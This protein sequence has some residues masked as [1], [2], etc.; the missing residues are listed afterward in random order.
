[1]KIIFNINYFTRPGQQICVSGAGNCLGNRD[2]SK[3]IVLKYTDNGNWAVEIEISKA[4]KLLEYKYFLKDESGSVIWEWGNE[5]SFVL[6]K[7]TKDLIYIIDSWRAPGKEEKAMF[8]SAFSNVIMKINSAAKGG[9]SRAKN[10]LQF[11]IQVPRIG[12]NYQVCVLGNQMKLGNWD[13]QKPLLLACDSS[14]LIWSGSINLSEIESPVKYKYGI[15]DTEKKELLTIEE[16][17]DRY[18]EIPSLNA[19][20]LLQIKTDE[21]FKYPLGNWKGAGVS[22]PVFSQRS[23]KS[24]GVGDFGDLIDF[25]DWAKI[26][27]MKMVQLLPVNE[28]IASHNWLDSYPYKSISVMALHPVYLNLEKM[29]ALN[30]KEKMTEYAVK[31]TELNASTHVDY[32]QV[33]K[34]K[35]E[36]YKLL[37]DQEKTTFFDREDYKLFFEANKEWLV[38]Y[39]AF[40]YLRDKMKSPDFRLWGRYSKYDK[41]A[42]LKLTSPKSKEWD[43]I[44]VHYF[45]QFHL[46]KQLSE[47]SSY[48]RGNGIVLKGDIPIGISPNSVE[49]WTEPEL[50]NLGAQ[51]GAPPDDFAVKGQN[52]GFPTY[53][54]EKMAEE[55]YSWWKKRLHKMADYFDAYRID[56]I[57]GFFRIWEIPEDAV[58][59]LLGYF[60]PA[61]PLTANE[62]EGFGV[63]FNYERMV[64]PYIRHYL[65]EDLFGEYAEEVIDD[66]LKSTVEDEYRMKDEFSS[67]I[68]I[69]AWFLKDVEE[70]NLSEKNR[71]IRDGL[72]DLIANVLFIQTGHDQWQPRISLQ[73]T[74]SFAAL[75]DYT[76]NQLNHL[77]LHFFYQRHDDFWYHKGMAKLPAIIEASNMLVCGEDLGMVPDCVPPVMDELNILS[78]EIQR[79]S[80][81]PKIKFAH[82]ADAP[83]LSVCTTSTHDMS[84]IRGWWEE[85]RETTQLFYNQELGNSGTAPFYAEPDICKQIIVQHLY[86]NA[87]WTTFPIQDLLA[88]DGRL[89][90]DKTQEEQINEPSNVRHKWRYRMQQSIE[91]LKN[92]KAFNNLLKSLIEASGRLSDY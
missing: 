45:I 22:I 63:P 18:L 42:I 68:K 51:A 86:S 66:F 6:P 32:P 26:V 83:Y 88:I 43:D 62:I 58:E 12:Q 44:A 67:Q 35:S 25:I 90:W 81:N 60:N 10:T 76:Q 19:D 48:A 39:A 52:W 8:S 61:L 36:Y 2:I 92:A 85:D 4:V 38:P 41:K 91:D 82:P 56:H 29:G 11:R 15:Y 30:D 16:G 71:K 49:A 84:T 1:M 33:L 64:Q 27:G 17:E 65:V 50:F 79:M 3:A 59:G 14:N 53:N 31:K 23:K 55:N 7:Q 72:F 40:V 24:F 20:S 13:K 70:E 75:D 74:A 28:T 21:S 80:K 5:R 54:W 47:V 9:V 69:N 89:R 77:Y 46:D 78:L 34:L 37:F 57:L 73:Q 87:M